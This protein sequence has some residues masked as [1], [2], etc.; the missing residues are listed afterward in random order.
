MKHHNIIGGLAIATIIGMAIGNHPA[1]ATAKPACDPNIAA[2]KAIVKA[3]TLVA[4][5]IINRFDGSA[6]DA[7]STKQLC[8]DSIVVPD[9]YSGENGMWGNG[10]GIGGLYTPI[11][12]PGNVYN[13]NNPGLYNPGSDYGSG[14]SEIGGI[15]WACTGYTSSIPQG[16]A[17]QF[18][19]ANPCGPTDGLQLPNG[20]NTGDGA[21]FC[22]NA[23]IYTDDGILHNWS[24]VGIVDDSGAIDV[25]GNPV[26]ADHVSLRDDVWTDSPTF[27][28]QYNPCG[29]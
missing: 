10:T 21:G 19:T 28:A 16:Y 1:H 17:I 20:M 14:T 2:T 4:S 3:V 5:K 18:E 15:G 26:K 7:E 25:N 23:E 13:P 6:C 27:D 22:V 8:W 12:I 11:N 24:L 9:A 29:Q